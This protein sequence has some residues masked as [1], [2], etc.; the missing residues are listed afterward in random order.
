MSGGNLQIQICDNVIDVF[1][2]DGCEAVSIGV[3]ASDLFHLA[4]LFNR[5]FGR[6]SAP[7]LKMV[8]NGVS[9]A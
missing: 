1:A 8:A 3:D 5:A 4:A 2:S 9:E 7:E 6:A